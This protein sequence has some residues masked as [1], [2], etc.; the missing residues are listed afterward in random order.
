MNLLAAMIVVTEIIEAVVIQ[1]GGRVEEN[2][3]ILEE[4]I[5]GIVVVEMVVLVAGQMVVI[6][7]VVKAKG[8]EGISMIYL[9]LCRTQLEGQN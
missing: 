1:I 3:V 5:T 4:M 9:V 8:N 2:S 7:N 6:I